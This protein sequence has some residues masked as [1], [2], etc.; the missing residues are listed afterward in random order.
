MYPFLEF[1]EPVKVKTM[2]LDTFCEVHKTG[3]IDVLHMD[4]QGAEGFAIKG[5]GRLRPRM[6]FLEVDETTHYD[7]AMPLPE[8]RALLEG[9][10][11]SKVWESAHDALYV[12]NMNSGLDDLTVCITSFKRGRYLDRALKSCRAAGIQRI[13]IAAVEPTEEVNEVIAAN[14][15]GWLSFDVSRIQDDIGCNNT[16]M[17]AAYRARTKRIIVL[18]DDDLLSSEFGRTYVDTIE[19]ELTAG[20]GFASWRPNVLYDNGSIAACD[21][22]SSDTAVYPSSSLEPILD[23]CLTHSPCVSVLDRETVI[24]AC[25][26]AEATLIENDSLE[27]PGMLLGTELLVYY[28]HIR[29]FPKWLYVNEVLCSFGSHAGSGTI[30][31][32]TKGRDA[33]EMLKRGYAL[34]KAQGKRAPVEIHPPKL[35]LLYSEFEAKDEEQAKRN[36]FAK[37]SWQ[38]HLSNADFIE[39]P[40]R[41][42]ELKR[43]GADLGDKPVPYVKDLFDA[44]CAYA[45]PEDIVVYA[46]RDIGFTTAAPERIL[47]GVKIGQ[48]ITV[49]PRR[50]PLPNGR[51]YK[52]VRNCKHDG[53]FDV[54][55]FTPAWWLVHRETKMPDM[56]IA[57][58]G[59]DTVFRTIAEEWADHKEL[60]DHVT[61]GPPEWNRS[62][63][64]T[65]DVCWHWPHE[66]E[67][68]TKRTSLPGQIH[69][70]RLA[71]AFFL[72]RKNFGV[73]ALL[74]AYGAPP[75]AV[76]FG[77]VSQTRR[78]VT[79]QPP[80]ERYHPQ[81]TQPPQPGLI[82]TKVPRT[83]RMTEP[84]QARRPPLPLPLPPPAR[85]LLPGYVPPVQARKPT[86]AE[87]NA[88]SQLGF[89]RK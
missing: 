28:R 61:D 87:L 25:K 24:H 41:D 2:R 14:S 72:E 7:G 51:L 75:R 81:T 63:A 68:E 57:R 88:K 47:N 55:A 73:V 78:R 89:A 33:V 20:V 37:D 76:P 60:L 59:W 23:H 71:R 12:F 83:V 11:Y 49:C 34:A 9:M 35:L 27:R 36:A 56:L 26:E 53:G 1:H 86:L 5:L 50:W 39:I 19:P 52:S 8:L 82:K 6:I 30:A 3:A 16:W 58:E 40:V 15:E 18:H 17:V 67:W 74:D 29:A 43:S 22:W 13:A 46:N 38:F 4:I 21:Y 64:Y 32:M 69:N 54:M 10:G 77:Q 65:D 80:E 66:S 31:A 70:R 84:I 44:G 42:G 48:G 85:S 45:M 62:L 79:F